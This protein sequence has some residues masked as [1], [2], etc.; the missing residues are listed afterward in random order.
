MAKDLYKKIKLLRKENSFSQEYLAKE[1]GMSRP[2]YIQIERG[3]RE[4]TISEARKLAGIFS[5]QLE[6]F[7]LPAKA[8]KAEIILEKEKIQKDSKTTGIRFIIPRADIIKFKEV[9]LYILEKVGAKPNI[10][11]TALYKLLYFIDFDYY[12]K[13]EEQL[14]GARYIKNHY[15]PTPI[16]FKKIVGEMKEKGEIER[17][18]SRYFQYDQ[19]KYLPCR[20]SD[21]RRLSAREVKHID[22]VLARL[23]DKNANELT[24]YSHSDIPWQ[25]HKNGEIISYESVFY[26]DTDHSVRDYEDEL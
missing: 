15:G 14:T 25:V 19:K 16:E 20:E 21:L 18:K 12:E 9:L 8:S 26:R 1:L 3:E 17:V 2:T 6:D 5:M 11:E 23:S 22:E 4:L 10:G 13:F 7:L 24:E